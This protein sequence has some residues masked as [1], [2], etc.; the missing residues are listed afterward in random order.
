[1]I[2]PTD[3]L[4]NYNMGSGVAESVAIIEADLRRDIPI[5]PPFV[6]D[7]VTDVAKAH[8]VPAV[9]IFG[10]TRASRA[11]RARHEVWRRLVESGRY[12][13]VQIGRWFG[14]CHG[15]VLYACGRLSRRKPR[16]YQ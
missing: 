16:P 6:R 8:G 4:G 12:S 7:T 13:S 1:M 2:S 11:V 15:T 14:R 9:L 10:R 3:I 5:L